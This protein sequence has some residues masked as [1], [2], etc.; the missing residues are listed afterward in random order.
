M[1]ARPKESEQS[2][3]SKTQ[4]LNECDQRSCARK[5]K[6]NEERISTLD[7]E[8]EAGDD[9][10]GEKGEETRNEGRVPV[11]QRG[12]RSIQDEGRKTTRDIGDCGRVDDARYISGTCRTKPQSK[13]VGRRFP[14]RPESPVSIHSLRL[15]PIYCRD[16]LSSARPSAVSELVLE[17]FSAPI[18]RACRFSHASK[19]PSLPPRRLLLADYWTVHV[20]GL[21]SD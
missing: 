5:R 8:N 16:G 21:R 18:G 14:G 6:A 4:E 1:S 15:V 7:K 3:L 10:E 12:S 13:E 20:T 19:R 9:D 11:F 2:D 17:E